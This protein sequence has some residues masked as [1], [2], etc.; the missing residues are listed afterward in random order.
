MK[1]DRFAKPIFV[2]PC[3][4]HHVA[5]LCQDLFGKLGPLPIQL[6]LLNTLL[7]HLLDS[8]L[9]HLDLLHCFSFDSISLT[10]T[11][12]QLL[13]HQF[14]NLIFDVVNSLGGDTCQLLQDLLAIHHSLLLSATLL[15]LSALFLFPLL[16]LHHLLLLHLLLLHL[17]LLVLLWCH[18]LLPIHLLLVTLL[19]PIT[20]LSISYGGLLPTCTNRKGGIHCTIIWNSPATGRRC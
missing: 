15:F 20:L 11:L 6:L 16:L 18:L 1:L 2:E 14:F 10:S 4:L 3:L 13:H 12:R 19:L 7:L 8:D 17:L 5:Q 9:C